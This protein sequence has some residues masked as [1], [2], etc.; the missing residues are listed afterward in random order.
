MSVP[1]GGGTS[2]AKGICRLGGGSLVIAAILF[3]L[4]GVAEFMHGPP[5]QGGIEILAWTG[6]HRSS[7][8]AVSELLFFAAM[9]LLPGL[10]ALHVSLTSVDRVEAAT[11][12]AIFAVI[13][14]VLVMLDIVHG[15]LAFP[16]YG[17]GVSTPDL[18]E[19]F[20]ALYYGGMHAVLLMAAVATLLLSLA[21]KRSIF[22]GWIA[23]LGMATAVADVAGSYPWLLGPVAI[24]VC[25]AFFAAWFAAVGMTLFTTSSID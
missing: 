5:P 25:Q 1:G 6:A 11:G 24:L 9:F 10:I 23:Y 12:C 18:A 13:V 8:Q 7:F 19:I 15:R 22:A 16:V 17:I 21:M 2:D 3:L 4:T 20:V 14:A